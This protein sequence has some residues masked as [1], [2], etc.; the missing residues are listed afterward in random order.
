MNYKKSWLRWKSALFGNCSTVV[1]Y[2]VT[3]KYLWIKE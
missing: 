2:N 3:G 1:F